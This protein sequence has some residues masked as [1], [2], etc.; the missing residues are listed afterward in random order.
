[1]TVTFDPKWSDA[2]LN[3]EIAKQQGY[4]FVEDDIPGSPFVTSPYGTYM[5]QAGFAHETLSDFY[6]DYCNDG[7]EM[8]D[9]LGRLRDLSGS[10]Y[11]DF[12]EN[13]MSYYCEI[14]GDCV[15]APPRVLAEQYMYTLSN[16]EN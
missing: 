8:R 4:V 13:L 14:L 15:L 16:L 7:E 11:G 1:M 12:L 9:V 6:P 10:A 3:M 5:G 2:R